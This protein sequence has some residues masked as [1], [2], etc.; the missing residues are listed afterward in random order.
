RQ[1]I[2]AM[3]E[4]A[5]Q[6]PWLVVCPASVKQNWAL[7][8]A[9]GSP[10][11]AIRVVGPGPPPA[12]GFAAWVVV[13]YARLKPH[14]DTLAEMPCAGFIFD[15]PHYLKNHRTQRARLARQL[16]EEAPDAV[17]HV[18]T[19]T[20]LTNR[21]RDL[22]PLL[23]LVRHSMGKSFLSFARR[24]CNAFHNGYGWVTDGA[25]NLDEL[26]VQLHGVMLRRTKNEV[27]NLPPKFRRWLPVDV[28]EGLGRR[29]MRRVLELLLAGALERR[30]AADDVLGSELSTGRRNARHQDYI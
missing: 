14:I 26:R 30:Q 6:G 16:T 28:D 13:S 17:M 15:E 9:A 1:S 24:Y 27:L 18:L 29:E 10:H 5:P 7:E 19:G 20:P 22:F 21:P 23:A 12:A 2:V 11:D 25:S 3:A 8:I 4:S